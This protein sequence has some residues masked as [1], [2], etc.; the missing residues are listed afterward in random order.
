MDVKAGSAPHVRDKAGRNVSRA[1]IRGMRTYRPLKEGTW[2]PSALIRRR[3]RAGETLA[4]CARQTRI[5]VVRWRRIEDALEPVSP[6]DEKA[7]RVRW[8]IELDQIQADLDSENQR[9]ALT[10]EQRIERAMC[11]WDELQHESYHP[12]IRMAAARH[13]MEYLLGKPVGRQVNAN[14]TVSS[15]EDLQKR[16]KSLPIPR[17]YAS[18]LEKHTGK[19]I[20]ELLPEAPTVDAETVT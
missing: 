9:G 19:S 8:G 5:P 1:S 12:A 4:D 7:I 13:E 18:Y 16:V 3:L 15:I 11:V 10:R 6:S 20:K 14:I 17:S 2:S